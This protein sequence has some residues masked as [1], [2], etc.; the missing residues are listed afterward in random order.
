VIGSPGLGRSINI[1][2][3]GGNEELMYALIIATGVLGL[4]LNSLFLRVERRVLHW[5]P[6]QRMEAAAR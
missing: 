5:H 4:V 3:S 1:A 6:S 2:R